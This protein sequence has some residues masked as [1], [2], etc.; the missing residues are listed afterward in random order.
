MESINHELLERMI[1]RYSIK[2][3]LGALA[4]ICF[5]KGAHIAENWQDAKLAKIWTKRADALNKLAITI[6]EQ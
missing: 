1:D 4:E 2:G 6:G 3:V 5:D